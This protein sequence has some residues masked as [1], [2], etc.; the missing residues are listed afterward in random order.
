M[1]ALNVANMSLIAALSLLSLMVKIILFFQQVPVRVPVLDVY[2]YFFVYFYCLLFE[3][4]FIIPYCGFVTDLI[5][6]IREDG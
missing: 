5:L 1:S 4:Y 6:S 3:F 2:V